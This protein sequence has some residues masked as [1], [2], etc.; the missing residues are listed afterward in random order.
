MSERQEFIKNKHG[1]DV[2][3][4]WKFETN[5]GY[6]GTDDSFTQHLVNDMGYTLHTLAQMSL[7]DLEVQL[8]EAHWESA[9]ERVDACA[10]PLEV[11]E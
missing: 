5:Y 10:Y 4:V 2:P 9:A 6:A 11:Q 3:L 7:S 8:N 1:E